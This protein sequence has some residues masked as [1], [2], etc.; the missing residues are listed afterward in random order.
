[1]LTATYLINR[2]PNSVLIGKTSYEI[3]FGHPLITAILKHLVA[4]VWLLI[5]M[6]HL[7]LLLPDLLDKHVPAKF[8]DFTGLPPHPST[9]IP[10]FS[11]AQGNL[12]PFP[13]SDY[14]SY[15]TFKLAPQLLVF[16]IVGTV[17]YFFFSRV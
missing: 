14:V 9:T 12:V 8:K 17:T 13:L 16:H 2:I 1:M 3:L 10:P 6:F 11:D 5:V 15:T 7:L 4:C